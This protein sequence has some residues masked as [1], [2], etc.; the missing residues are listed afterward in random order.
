MYCIY[1][2]RLYEI[3]GGTKCHK[4]T[5][6]PKVLAVSGSESSCASIGNVTWSSTS[7]SLIRRNRTSARNVVPDLTFVLLLA[8]IV[9]SRQGMPVNGQRVVDV[10][11][12]IRARAV[13]GVTAPPLRRRR[14]ARAGV[15]AERLV[16]NDGRV[17]HL[18]VGRNVLAHA[19]S[20]LRQ[21]PSAATDV[22]RALRHALP[23][24]RIAVRWR[25]DIQVI[26]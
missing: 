17:I 12:W 11:G 8:L 4:L 14:M 22:V 20:A 5:Q 18:R 2:G 7:T 26:A 13:D 23:S 6:A 19:A 21:H 10:L 25:L 9:L 16:V 15:A 3:R 1:R 24:D